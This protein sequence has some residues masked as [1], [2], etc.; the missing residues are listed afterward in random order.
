METSIPVD[1][2]KFN[3]LE[4]RHHQS[5][6]LLT[7]DTSIPSVGSHGKLSEE[8]GSGGHDISAVPSRQS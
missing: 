1:D 2:D 3:H 7:I 8:T 4:M 6:G 5:L